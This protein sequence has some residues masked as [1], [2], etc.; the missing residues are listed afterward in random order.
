MGIRDRDPG[1]ALTVVHP[2]P[3]PYD[4]RACRLLRGPAGLLLAQVLEHLA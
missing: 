4:D 2:E 3:A 1:A